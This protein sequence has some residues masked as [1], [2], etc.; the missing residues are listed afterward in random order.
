M[1]FASSPPKGSISKGRSREGAELPTDGAP[2]RPPLKLV[3]RVAKADLED[4]KLVRLEY[5]PFDV[6]VSLVDGKA[7]AIE[8]ACNHAGASLSEGWL[9]GDRVVCPLHG[10]VFSMKTGALIAPAGLCGPQRTYRVV[11][12]GDDYVVYDDFKVVL[13]Q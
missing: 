10:Y 9:E 5:D 13:I 1:C 12:E 8:D 2:G 7:Y 3:A 4:G 6:L 11:E